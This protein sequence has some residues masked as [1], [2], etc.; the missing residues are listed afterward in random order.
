MIHPERIRPLNRGPVRPGRYVVYWMQ[1]SQRAEYNHALEYAIQ[2]AN[3]RNQPAVCFFGLTPDFPDANLRHYAFMLEGL[4][5]VDRALRKRGIRFVVRIGE[6]PEGL[7]DVAAR[8]SSVVV[9]AG[10]L[11][12][13]RE[14]RQK[15]ASRLSCLLV[16]VESDAVCPVEIASPKEEYAAATLRPKIHRLL[17]RFLAP[18]K[19]TPVKRDSLGLR[20]RG[21]RVD[22]VR[23]LLGKLPIDQSVRPAHGFTGGTSV[24]EKR[25]ARFIERDLKDYA[26]LHGDPSLDITSRL[27]PYLHFG[28]ISALKAALAVQRARGRPKASKAGFLEELIVRRELSLNFVRYNRHHAS[29][30]ALPDWALRTL[31]AHAKDRRP[32]TYA[33]DELEAAR[34]HDPYWN[35]AMREM[36][37]TGFMHNYMR[38]YWGKKILEWAHTPE[39]AFRNTLY[40]NNK[41]FLDG[42][43]PNS[44]AGV[45]WCFGKHD[46]PWAERPIFGTVRY[47]NA[48]GLER[49]FNIE[50]YVRR[51]EALGTS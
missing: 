37:R 2:S 24:A 26:A 1:A 11:P 44:F 12:V 27:S 7:L 47:M 28:Q 36:L 38:M 15:A 18:L 8:A 48:R 51:V 43:D 32:Y 29:L 33:L 22:R 46:R 21:E 17:P 31:R 35:A 25:L 23:A 9:D 10:Y 19:K 6:P 39:E 40:L 42:R 3:E 34:T 45:A 20:L 16:Q 50:A 41:Y 13:E 5:D 14:W 30:R 49:K 4:A